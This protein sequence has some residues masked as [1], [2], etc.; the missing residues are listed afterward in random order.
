MH[1]GARASR[2]CGGDHTWGRWGALGNSTV[3]PKSHYGHG[4]NPLRKKKGDV[5]VLKG[6]SLLFLKACWDAEPALSP[7]KPNTY[8]FLPFLLH[9]GVPCGLVSH[10]F[11]G[12]FSHVDA[13]ISTFYLFSFGSGPWVGAAIP[14]AMSQV[15][16]FAGL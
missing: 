2:G 4:Y 8:Q 9:F 6:G 11:L 13:F 5:F 15:R 7:S 10:V 3:K 1:G 16:V 14:V 12:Y